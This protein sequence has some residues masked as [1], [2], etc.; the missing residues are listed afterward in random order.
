MFK[1][2]HFS[3]VS[4]Y[5]LFMIITVRLI[6]SLVLKLLLKIISFITIFLGQILINIFSQDCKVKQ[7]LIYDS[8]FPHFN[9]LFSP[10]VFVCFQTFQL[11]V[12][13]FFFV[14]P[15]HYRHLCFFPN[16]VILLVE[17]AFGEM[18]ARSSSFWSLWPRCSIDLE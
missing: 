14:R 8:P 2:K 1:M 13:G 12:S 9:A 4:S 11:L 7:P 5:V 10:K 17:I 16:V 18:N 15:F 3:V 6:C